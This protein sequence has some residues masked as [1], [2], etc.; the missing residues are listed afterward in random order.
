MGFEIILSIVVFVVVILF[1]LSFI[2]GLFMF[3]ITMI[4]GSPRN[5]FNKKK[6]ILM[7]R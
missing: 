6:K 3:N 5:Y 4:P 7:S 1:I 2:A